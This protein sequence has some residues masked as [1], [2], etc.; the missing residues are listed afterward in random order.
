MKFLFCA[1][2]PMELWSTFPELP[3]RQDLIPGQVYSGPRGDYLVHGVGVT[4]TTLHLTQLL[5]QAHEYNCII[6][7]GICGL[8][9]HAARV[10]QLYL[11]E[12]VH[13]IEEAMGDL[14]AESPYGFI[15]MERLLPDH[16]VEIHNEGLQPEL[17][18]N[19]LEFIPELEFI[20]RVR[21]ITVSNVTGTQETA[22]ERESLFHADVESM[23]GA[24]AARVAQ[25][26][27]LPFL[28]IRSISNLATTRDQSSWKIQEALHSLKEFFENV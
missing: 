16:H 4:E 2:T 3:T 7:I 18:G 13:V 5:S 6:Q 14:G 26:F 20:P 9:P 23:E 24:A 21:G 8:Y 28:Q 12:V 15:P 11:T 10:Q 22:E 17:A 25:Q 1:A 27:N 19:L